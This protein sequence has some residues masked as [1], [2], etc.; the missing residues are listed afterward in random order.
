MIC[1]KIIPVDKL[2]KCKFQDNLEFMQWVK[3]FWEQNFP[4]GE[5][6]AVT[7]RKGG[8]PVSNG[9]GATKPTS[10]TSAPRTKPVSNTAGKPIAT[11]LFQQLIYS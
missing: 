6:D 3:R 11:R 4:G 2:M 9:G 8:A 1:Y 10:R 5:Y 7:R